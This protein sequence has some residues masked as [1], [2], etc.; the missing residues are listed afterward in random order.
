[1]PKLTVVFTGSPSETYQP[2][3]GGIQ[4][5]EF[6]FCE[7]NKKNG[8]NKTVIFRGKKEEVLLSENAK[9]ISI[10]AEDVKLGGI[11]DSV[12]FSLNASAIINELGIKGEDCVHFT[13]LIPAMVHLDNPVNGY[14]EKNRNIIKTKFFY[15][16]HNV[17]YGVVD[18]PE[19]IFVNYPDEWKY[20]HDAERRVIDRVDDVFVTCKKYTSELSGKFNRNIKYLPNTVGNISNYEIAT[21]NGSKYKTILTLCRIEEVKNLERLLVAFKKAKKIDDKIKLII[22]GDGSLLEKL[23]NTC[24]KE[25]LKQCTK[26]DISVSRNLESVLDAYDVVFTGKVE[27]KYKRYLFEMSDCVALFSLREICSLFGLEA[28]AYGKRILAS[29]IP[30]WEDYQDFGADILLS[31]PYNVD[32][33]TQTIIRGTADIKEQVNEISTKNKDV[34]QRHYSPNVV[35][36]IRYSFYE[37]SLRSDL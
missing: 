20:L 17:H 2:D 18:K 5:A 25:G 28:I 34:Y 35:S 10:F 32:E 4:L 22:G 31:D 6:S 30:G 19:D 9:L 16:I 13:S 11:A 21:N 29:K 1:M 15:T 33:M 27:G 3:S 8:W 23:I 36:S 26:T 14:L 7:S 12:S 37:D 24:N